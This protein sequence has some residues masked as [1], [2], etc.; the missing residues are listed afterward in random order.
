MSSA[1]W[2]ESDL[3]DCAGHLDFTALIEASEFY[4]REPGICALRRG[5]VLAR[6]SGWESTASLRI[7]I[8]NV[9]AILDVGS[10]KPKLEIVK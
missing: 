8:R 7:A 4:D 1:M 9:L 2:N 5:Y 3:A 10:E 6:L